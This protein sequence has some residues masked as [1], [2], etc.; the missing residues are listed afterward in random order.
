MVFKLEE[1]MSIHNWKETPEDF[2]EAEHSS[3][4]NILHPL[5]AEIINK[6][7]P[8]TLLDYGCGDGRLLELLNR[9]IEISVFD[10]SPEMLRHIKVKRGGL[11]KQIYSS[12]TELP[13]EHFDVALLSMVL[14]CIDDKAE[15]ANV[16]NNVSRAIKENGRVIISLS[17]PCFRQYRFSNFHTSFGEKQLFDYLND[18]N[19]FNVTIHDKGPD[20]ITFED[21]H[22]SLSFTINQLSKAGLVIESIIETTDDL[23]HS[24]SNSL[25]SPYIILICK[26]NE[27]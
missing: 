13:I 25:Y 10:R 21:Y 11:L 22:Y 17:H 3:Q 4:K 16:C 5:T 12:T 9:G 26:H 14:M 24:R 15:Y 20:E 1:S 6:L 8:K 23:K 18:G 7:K 2:F 19:P 27:K